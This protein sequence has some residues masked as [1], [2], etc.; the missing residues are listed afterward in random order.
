MLNGLEKLKRC[1][2]IIETDKAGHAL[3]RMKIRNI[4]IEEVKKSLIDY[5]NI[6][7]IE[8]YKPEK[9]KNRYRVFYRKSK[10][11]ILVIGVILNKKCIIKTVFPISEKLQKK[12]VMKWKKQK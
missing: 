12:M 10:H 11:K 5:K 3:Q 7:K 6:I 2:K 1:S 4:S 9:F 8:S